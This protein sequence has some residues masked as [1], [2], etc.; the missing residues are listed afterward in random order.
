MNQI[1][2][3]KF[4]SDMRKK[5]DLTQKQLAFRLNVTDKTIEFLRN[6]IPSRKPL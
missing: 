5:Q 2:M 4:I 6:P 1:K 3:G